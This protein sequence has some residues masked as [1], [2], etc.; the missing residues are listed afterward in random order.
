MRFRAIYTFLWFLDKQM[1][2][3]IGVAVFWRQDGAGLEM[4]RLRGRGMGCLCLLE[5][6]GLLLSAGLCSAG[7]AS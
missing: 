2:G 3:P 4:I 7:S 1:I 5:G 6:N